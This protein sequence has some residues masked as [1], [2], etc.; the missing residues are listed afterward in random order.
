[1]KKN[2]SILM[3]LVLLLATAAVGQNH[4]QFPN[5]SF[6]NWT[7]T[8]SNRAV[9]RGWHSFNEA[10]GG[11]AWAVG[12][13]SDAADD[14]FG[15]TNHA[16]KI[17]SKK[18]MGI[19]ANGAMTIGKMYVGSTNQSSDNN[20]IRTVRSE[21]DSAGGRW[22]MAGRP[23]SVRLWVK[24]VMASQSVIATCKMHIHGDYDY[25]DIP[26]H[27]AGSAQTGKIANVF[28]EMVKNQGRASYNG[29]EI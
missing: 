6:K 28:C 12:N 29:W 27:N 16:C 26:S 22:S 25:K 23:D 11:W 9:P 17:Y 8:N 5:P 3:A 18:V 4:Y 13:H 19:N 2:F 10:D 14:R 7:A 21:A 15:N 1:M 24:F 20:Y